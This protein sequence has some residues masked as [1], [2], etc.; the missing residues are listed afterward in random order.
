MKRDYH[1]IHKEYLQSGL[2]LRAFCLRENLP[3]NSIGKFFKKKGLNLH[4]VKTRH[5]IELIRYIE[6]ELIRTGQSLSK[7]AKKHNLTTRNILHS[8]RVRGVVLPK[9]NLLG[10][11]TCKHPR[12][13]NNITT[14]LQAYL[15]GWIYSDGCISEKRN[16]LFFRLSKVDIEI[17][18]L[19]RNLLN[20][21]LGESR[22][23]GRD[24]TIFSIGNKFI[25]RDIM[26]L[27]CVPNKS[28]ECMDMPDIPLNLKRHFIRGF[29]DGDGSIY[30]N[31]DKNVPT[32]SFTSK[33][34]EILESI[35]SYL[36]DFDIIGV[37]KYTKPVWR[38]FIQSKSGIL[39]FY[40]HIYFNSNYSLS[41]KKAK[42][43]MYVNTEVRVGSKEPITP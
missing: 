26:A 41:R 19:F 31:K 5:G 28:Y 39:N 24:Y 32:I 12:L 33:S 35:A 37:T 2:S 27:G 11:Y 17:T 20:G 42:F 38:L 16:V 43:D 29:F 15:L 36:E 22:F 3:Y 40:S 25:V 13:F 34:F 21:Y 23:E 18:L 7:V 8:C 6:K 10:S 1:K 14:E 4:I 9:D 30:I